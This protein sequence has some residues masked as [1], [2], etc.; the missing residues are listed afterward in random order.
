MKISAGAADRFVA[1]PD[2]NILCVLLYGPDQ[3]LV[4]ERAES[5]GRSSI[6]DLSDPFNV[7]ELN[8]AS[9][10][11]D[12]ARLTDEAS[13]L[14]FGG[15]RRFIRVRNAG[16]S[17]T[18]TLEAYLQGPSPGALVVVEAQELGPRSSLRILFEGHVSA[19]A[20]ACYPDEGAAL[21]KIIEQMLRDL[22]VFIDND[23]LTLLGQTMG[24]DRALVRRE[25]GKLS[26]YVGEGN[27]A[28]I[29]DVEACLVNSG[30]VS[31]DQ[32]AFSVAD[33]KTAD[34]DNS[35]QKALKEG[36]SEVAILRSLQRHFQR[37]D[38]V[39]SQVASGNSAP[40]V[41]GGLRPPVFFKFKERFGRQV[42][43]W[44]P[45]RVQQALSILTE[46]EA[47]CKTTGTPVELICG[48]AIM[49]ISRMS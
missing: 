45:D 19:A 5:L 29:E 6:D 48:R 32:I 38:W 22:G 20:I 2:K 14:S 15:G 31:L 25:I 30:T 34:A 36:V 1:Q 39:V 23:A 12:P 21:L 42:R 7:I 24:D 18:K 4:K 33:G 49:A 35:Y 9:L 3:G 43:R 16:D 27:R 40:S 47:A 11:D 28:T 17:L 37:L 26:L 10:K 46:A 8:S 41:I 13:A 44:P